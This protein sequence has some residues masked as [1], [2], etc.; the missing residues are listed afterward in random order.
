M[1]KGSVPG[2]GARRKWPGGG[3]TKEVARGA[4][5]KE[6][7]R[8]ALHQASVPRVGAHRKIPGGRVSCKC[9]GVAAATAATDDGMNL[10]YNFSVESGLIPE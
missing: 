2:G 4:C 8:G 6:V 1:G 9:S 7:S 3:G 5:T 10:G